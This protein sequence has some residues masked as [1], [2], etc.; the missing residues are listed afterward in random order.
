MHQFVFLAYMA[1]LRKTVNVA[2]A[3]VL[4]ILTAVVKIMCVQFCFLQYLCP[5]IWSH[6]QHDPTG[7]RQI[8]ER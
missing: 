3:A 5:Y 8:R 2:L 4:F 6:D 1:V 7:S